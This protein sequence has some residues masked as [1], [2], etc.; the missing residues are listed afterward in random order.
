MADHASGAGAS[1]TG[2]S[3]ASP[4]GAA[5]KERYVY[6]I[7]ARLEE[8]ENNL[9]RVAERTDRITITANLSTKTASIDLLLNVVAANAAGGVTTY[10]AS[11]Y[12]TGSTFA[13]GTGG[14]SSA[15]NLAQAAMEGVVALKLLELDPAKR[16]YPN[17]DKTVITRCTHTLAASGGSNATFSA[18]LEFPIEVISL[19]G[20][21]S[22]IEGKVFLN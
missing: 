22:V 21:G 18:L 2:T 13:S 8:E 11:H 15:P 19:P 17:P 4:Q 16:L 20:G 1:V 10:T 5:S 6:G 7:L 9:T 3:H 14:D 12:L